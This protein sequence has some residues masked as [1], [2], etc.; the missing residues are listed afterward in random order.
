LKKKMASVTEDEFKRMGAFI[1]ELAK[2]I[3]LNGMLD[4]MI[5]AYQRHLS[6]QDVRAMLAFYNTPNGQKLLGEQPAMMS[7]GRQAM[8]PRMQKMM[9]DLM[10][11]VE[12]TV[13]EDSGKTV[14]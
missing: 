4:D 9:S 3:D 13:R 8:Q 6:Q 7:E 11:R 14:P 12:Q 10:D 5:P 2:K 1:D